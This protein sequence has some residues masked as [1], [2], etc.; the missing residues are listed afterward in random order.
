M[1]KDED[2]KVVS[3]LTLNYAQ[4]D[5]PHVEFSSNKTWEKE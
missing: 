3:G 4:T 5:N 1:K 2:Q